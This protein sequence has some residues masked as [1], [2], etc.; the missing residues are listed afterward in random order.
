MPI[1]VFFG[2]ISFF[3]LLIFFFIVR[4]FLRKGFGEAAFRKQLRKFPPV[5]SVGC[6]L[7]ARI[8]K[9]SSAGEVY[10][11]LYEAAKEKVNEKFQTADP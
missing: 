1:T 8:K 2:L 3:N 4:M 6:K 9:G 5:Q 11:E 10:D 7:H